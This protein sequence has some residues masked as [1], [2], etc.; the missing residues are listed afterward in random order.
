MLVQ[1]TM[2]CPLGMARMT[3]PTRA[4]TCDHLQCFDADTYL[5][6]NE[7]KPKWLCPVCNRPAYFETLFLDGFY[8][9]LLQSP[10]FRALATNDIVLNQVRVTVWTFNLKNTVSFL[11]AGVIIYWLMP[12][13]G[14][15]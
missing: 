5:R 4:S 7:K 9:Q 6:M 1:V 2:S 10:K 8:I 12:S 15:M 11:L 3:Y 13:W 14:K